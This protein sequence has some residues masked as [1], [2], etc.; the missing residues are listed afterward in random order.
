M[1]V[2]FKAHWPIVI[3]A[4]FVRG[5]G[6][7]KLSRRCFLAARQ[8]LLCFDD[9]THVAII[10][11]LFQLHA[12]PVAGSCLRRCT[13]AVGI[14]YREPIKVKTGTH[15]V[16]LERCHDNRVTCRADDL[17]RAANSIVDINL[18]TTRRKACRCSAQ[19]DDK[20]FRRT[21]LKPNTAI[22]VMVRYV[23]FIVQNM[24][25]VGIIPH[26][27]CGQI[28]ATYLHAIDTVVPHQI[29]MDQRPDVVIKRGQPFNLACTTPSIQS[30][31]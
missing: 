14:E 2:N 29:A 18:N 12:S 21:A 25:H 15:G 31:K 16:V 8:S 19:F 3:A 23:D 24:H 20:A 1:T 6:A 9:H 27:L 17:N 28:S 10:A 11:I 30:L 7:H 13:I 26:T 4:L 5:Q 22:G